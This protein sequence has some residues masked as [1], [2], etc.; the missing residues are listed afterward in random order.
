MML[1]AKTT[2]FFVKPSH[3]IIA[4]KNGVIMHYD[5]ALVI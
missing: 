3:K 4:L 1:L 2:S 5:V